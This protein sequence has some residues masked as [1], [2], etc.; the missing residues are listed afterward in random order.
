M[1]SGEVVARH[2]K[3]RQ[4]VRVRWQDGIFSAA[5]TAET[6][7]ENVWLA[8]TLTDLQVNGYGAVS[9]QEPD[10]SQDDLLK[11]VRALQR[12][13]CGQ[14]LFTLVTNEWSAILNQVRHVRKLRAQSPELNAALPG[15]HIEGPFMSPVPGFVGAHSPE[16]MLSPTPEHICQLREACG[17]DPVLLTVAPERD[18]VLEAIKLAVSLGITVSLGHTNASYETIQQ[19]IKNGA[20]SY[21][22]FGNGCPQALD[23][24]DNILWRVLNTQGLSVGLIVDNIHVSPMLLKIFHRLLDTSKVWYTT[25][26]VSPAGALPGTYYFGKTAF[27]VGADQ[28]VKEPGKTNFAGSALRPIEGV[29]R[30][31]EMLDCPWQT[32]WERFSDQ[33]RALM[34]MDVNQLQSGKPANFCVIDMDQSTV[35]THISGRLHATLPARSWLNFAGI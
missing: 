33:P 16:L 5:G 8:P 19:A 28:V 31:A 9:F 29:F 26:A 14:C 6:A 27:V 1:G 20:R 23:R 7:P 3:T 25:D 34:K 17:D 11:A 24:H 22:H 21:T 35:K 18:G 4:P 2:Y 15:F 12:D 32:A 13:A 10:I 30:A